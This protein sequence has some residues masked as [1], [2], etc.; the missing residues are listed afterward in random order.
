MTNKIKLLDIDFHF[1]IGFLYELIENT[2]MNLVELGSQDPALLTPKLMYYSRAYAN[3]RLDK[4]VDFNM[5]DIFDLIDENGGIFGDFC[6]KFNQA[7]ANS[8]NQGVPETDDKKK[9]TKK[10]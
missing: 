5:N 10:K 2:G 7:F 6:N 8:M 1:G 4:E 3:K 9:V